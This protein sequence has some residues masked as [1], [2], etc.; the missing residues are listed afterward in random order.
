MS[1]KL[2]SSSAG[3]SRKRHHRIIGA[4]AAESFGVG[5]ELEAL[6]GFAPFRRR[7]SPGM[8]VRGSGKGERMLATSHHAGGNTTFGVRY[9]LGA[10]S[11]TNGRARHMTF[12]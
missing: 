1:T 9:S 4:R 2:A 11:M 3:K 10:W 7:D 6:G 5:A 8:R 12:P